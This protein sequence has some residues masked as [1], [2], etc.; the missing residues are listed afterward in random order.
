MKKPVQEYPNDKITVRFDPKSCI[1]TAH[2][3]QTLP[4]VFDT[5]KSPWV[6]V[7]GSQ[8]EQI[9]ETV[10]GCPSGALSFEARP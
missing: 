3:V 10:N 7:D 1:H 4:A 6:N 9:I 8:V 5:G 2:C